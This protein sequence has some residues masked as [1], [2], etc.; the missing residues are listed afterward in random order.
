MTEKQKLEM[1]I[2]KLGANLKL[3]APLMVNIRGAI[4]FNTAKDAKEFMKNFPV[5]PIDFK[6]K[7][8]F[9]EK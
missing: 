6:Y 9:E 4:I 7:L 2:T 3:G 5:N 1:L 8:Y